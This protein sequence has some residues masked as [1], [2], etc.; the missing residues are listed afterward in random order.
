MTTCFLAPDPVQS[1]FLLPGT[2]TPGNGVQLFTYTAGTTTKATVYKDSL[3]AASWTDPIVLDSGGNLPSGGSVWIATGIKIKAVWAPFND[4]DP[5][6]SPFRTI[7]NISGVND[8]SST[9]SEWI[10]GPAPTFIGTTQFSLAGDQTLTFTVGRR[11]KATVSAGTIYGTIT[12]S[13]FGA[14][15]T[16][17]TVALD[18]AAV[19]DGGLSVVWVGILDPTNP[20]TV[21]LNAIRCTVSG[22][23]NAILLTPIV[24]VASPAYANG[25][26]YVFTPTA[27]S[28]GNVTLKVG[29]NAA[30]NAYAPDGIA[31][32]AEYDLMGSQ[33]E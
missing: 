16:T 6:G 20:S 33:V 17:V 30:L 8:V 11:I 3:G 28:T 19:F 7:D 32:I 13:S 22:T 4:T 18:A 21:Y 1:T 25:Q 12:V 10:L 9:L 5:P 27:I 24:G 14:G 2:N 31:R 29:P 26:K 15:V 23:A